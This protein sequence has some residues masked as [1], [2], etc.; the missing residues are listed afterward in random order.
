MI[1]RQKDLLNQLDN[2]TFDKQEFLKKHSILDRTLR[3]DLNALAERGEIFEDK[4]SYLRKQC[5]GKLTKLAHNNEL[6]PAMM[7]NIVM[8]GV[9]KKSD[10]TADV[11][12][13]GLDAG[14]QEIIKFSRTSDDADGS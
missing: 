12:L 9:T 1:Q 8:S 14:L 11:N 3:R 6:S 2:N 7:L 4:L 10:I 5:L 13:T